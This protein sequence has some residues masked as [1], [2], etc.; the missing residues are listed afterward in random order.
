MNQI[1]VL[2]FAHNTPKLASLYV[3]FSYVQANT[4][5]ME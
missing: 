4:Y 2:F 1:S 3:L 5:A